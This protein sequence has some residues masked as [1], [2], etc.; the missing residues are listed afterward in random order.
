MTVIYHA[1]PMANLPSIV[2]HGL[3]PSPWENGTYFANTPGYAAAF[4]RLRMVTGDI[5]VFPVDTDDFDPE[6]I[7]PGDDHNPGFFPDDLVVTFI[8]GEIPWDQ[9]GDDI[10]VF[11]EQEAH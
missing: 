7:M 2:E 8:R 3:K 5:V 1:T 10:T 11:E 4:M 6:R 9:I